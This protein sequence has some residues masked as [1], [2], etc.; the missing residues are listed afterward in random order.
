MRDQANAHV[1]SNHA[2]KQRRQIYSRLK[3]VFCDAEKVQNMT[4]RRVPR[5]DAASG[6]RAAVCTVL[7]LD[8]QNNQIESKQVSDQLLQFYVYS[9]SQVG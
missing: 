7:V 9:R 8:E 1:E 2:S 3:I 5:C 6:M 4:R